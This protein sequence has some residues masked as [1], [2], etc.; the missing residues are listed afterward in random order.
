MVE[1]REDVPK[2]GLVVSVTVDTT[3]LSAFPV[4]VSSFSFAI[5]DVVSIS[6]SVD[7][8]ALIM[9]FAVVPSMAVV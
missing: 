7:M 8:G 4:V 6:F 5:E 3:D 2:P 9:E 1:R